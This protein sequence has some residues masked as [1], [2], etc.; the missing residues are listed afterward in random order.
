VKVDLF[1]SFRDIFILKKLA[2]WTKTPPHARP[3][4]YQENEKKAL[5]CSGMN[6]GKKWR[7]PTNCY[8]DFQLERP[9][10]SFF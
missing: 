6:W 4:E 7:P 8:R 3:I 1:F 10:V 9:P 2:Y 5:F